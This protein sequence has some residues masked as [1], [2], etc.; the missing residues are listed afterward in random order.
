[1]RHVLGESKWVMDHATK[2][3]KPAKATAA[4]FKIHHAHPTPN[5]APRDGLAVEPITFDPSE[6]QIKDTLTYRDPTGGRWRGLKPARS[7][8]RTSGSGHAG[9][10]PRR[11]A[12]A[13]MVKD[14]QNRAWSLAAGQGTRADGAHSMQPI[15][16]VYASVSKGILRTHFDAAGRDRQSVPVAW[17]EGEGT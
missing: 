3:S 13:M 14:K 5:A 16:R 6:P 11:L 1:M 7:M 4:S 9:K 17:R 12:G 10:T 8:G 2:P 15:D